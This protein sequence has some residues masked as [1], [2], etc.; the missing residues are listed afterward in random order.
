MP[1]VSPSQGLGTLNVALTNF[2]K[3][4][5]PADLIADSVAPRVPVD[6]QSYQYLI[7]D[8]SRR[9]NPGSTIR[10]PGG[11]PKQIRFT[12][13][14]D[15]YFCD[16]H[17]L[18]A[19]V[20]RETEAT[21]LN[22]GFSSKKRAAAQIMDQLQ[23]G[24]EIEVAAG[25]A[26]ITGNTETLSGTSMWSD[27]SGTSHPIADIQD[28]IL[29]VRKAGVRANSLILPPDVVRSLVSHPDIKAK[30]NAID[31]GAITLDML[32]R[33]MGLPILDAGAVVTDG[34]GDDSFVWGQN[35]FVAY[36]QP[37]SSQDDLSVMKT[38]VDATQGIDGYEVL[39]WPDA[40]L[41]TKRDWVS[42]DMYYDVKLTAPEAAFA[43]LN[44]STAYSPS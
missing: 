39:E 26:A 31:P 35:A 8:K 6:R 16:S 24:R 1:P 14:V 17:S 18:E 34:A 7:F 29:M 37:V 41:S 15:K 33:V 5:S 36:V 25:F 42:S 32:S 12:Y 43:F 44:A 10:M 3:D 28:A 22:L 21:S 19:A 38:F 9:Q 27:Y 4:Y 11:R 2:A 30:F 20:P 13:S 40:H 23:L